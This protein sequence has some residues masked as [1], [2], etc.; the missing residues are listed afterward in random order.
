VGL[1]C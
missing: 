1:L